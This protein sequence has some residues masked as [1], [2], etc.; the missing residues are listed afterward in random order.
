MNIL[1]LKSVI[2]FLNRQV[3]VGFWIMA[4]STMLSAYQ[5]S[6]SQ[7]IFDIMYQEEALKVEMETDMEVLKDERYLA[8]Q[9]PARLSFKDKY[10]KKHN[11]EIKVGQRGNFRRIHCSELPP[12]KLNFKKGDLKAAGLAKWDDMKLVTHCISDKAIA[13]DLILREA[14]TYKLFNEITDQSFRIQLLKITYIDTNSGKKT[15]Q[16]AFLI[17]DAAQLK[18]RLDATVCE[19]CYNLPIDRFDQQQLLQASLFQYLIG[20]SDW[21]LSTT[22]NL[23]L[24]EKDG[25]IMPIPYDF[26]FSG[27][28]NASYAIPSGSY[29]MDGI[30]D[31]VYLG[32]EQTIDQLDETKSHFFQKRQDLIQL[33]KEF[34]LLDFSSRSEVIDYLTIF[35]EEHIHDIKIPEKKEPISIDAP[36]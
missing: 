35:F 21:S 33:V 31:R 18:A 25:K 14:L 4:S 28:V 29:V 19:E 16:W 6:A 24:L 10:G 23:K 13:E 2:K 20:N 15:R 12:L 7:S 8:E 5:V 22:R 30:K 9:I 36:K 3:L 34:N 32:F 17:E 1:K 11:W 26:D 27:L